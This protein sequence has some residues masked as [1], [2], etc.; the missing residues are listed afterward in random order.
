M[1][2]SH[3]VLLFVVLGEQKF[4]PWLAFCHSVN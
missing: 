2:V 4:T 1:S 3:G